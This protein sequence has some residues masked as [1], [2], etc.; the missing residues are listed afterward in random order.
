[1]AGPLALG[2]AGPTL[3]NGVLNFTDTTGKDRT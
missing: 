2:R 1:M 3:G